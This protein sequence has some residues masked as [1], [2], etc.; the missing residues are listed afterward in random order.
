MP[1]KASYLLLAGGGAVVAVAG[2]KGWSPGATLRDVLSGKDPSHLEQTS[3]IAQQSYGYGYG[4]GAPIGVTGFGGPGAISNNAIAN[5]SLQQIGF[6]YKWG[7][8]PITGAT[9]CSGWANMIV[10]WINRRA[11]P[12]F[13]AG[14]Y[15]G[16][17]HGPNTIAWLAWNG[18]YRIPLAQA[19]PGDLAVWQT[20]MGIIVDN[21]Q[22]MVS[23]LNPSLGTQE[24]TIQGASP[25][26]EM[27]F[28][29]RLKQ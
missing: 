19:R 5:S 1:V 6:A 12:G 17:T 23:D 13:A 2:F 10:G 15:N 28:V 18:C 16:Q 29:E 8:A 24:T 4:Y 7:A 9:D 25:P 11:I 22:H 14:T 3:Q 21:G 26:L 20:H 27:L